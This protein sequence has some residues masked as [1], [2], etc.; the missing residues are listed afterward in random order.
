MADMRRRLARIEAA[1]DEVALEILVSVSWAED[2]PLDP[3]PDQEMIWLTW[4]E[5]DCA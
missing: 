5:E 4:P 1:L 2:E 3:D